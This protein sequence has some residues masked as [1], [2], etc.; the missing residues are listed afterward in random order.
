ML[1]DMKANKDY[2]FSKLDRWIKKNLKSINAASKNNAYQN[3]FDCEALLIPINQTRYHWL[4]MAVDLK[5]GKIYIV[6][7]MTTSSSTAKEYKGLISRFLDDYLA[8]YPVQNPTFGKPS[9]WP[10]EICTHTPR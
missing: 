9:E 6:N 3:L 1:E 8:A 7:S 10:V 5:L 2:K 4:M